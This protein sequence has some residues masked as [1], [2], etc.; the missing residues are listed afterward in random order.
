[1]LTLLRQQKEAYKQYFDDLLLMQR[2]G[3]GTKE[4][5][6][7]CKSRLFEKL[8]AIEIFKQKKKAA[9]EPT[10]TTLNYA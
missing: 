7:N 5:V 9:C 3:T 2:S 1:M 4:N 6:A 10:Q 8:K